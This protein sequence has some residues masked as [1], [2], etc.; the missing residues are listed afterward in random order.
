MVQREESLVGFNHAG[1]CQ[2]I[3]KH[4]AQAS[5]DLV[6]PVE[7]GLEVDARDFGGIRA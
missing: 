3:F 2:P 7:G 4:L 1:Q 6:P 5:H